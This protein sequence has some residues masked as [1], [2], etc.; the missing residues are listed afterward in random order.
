MSAS[1]NSSGY[2]GNFNPGVV[3]TIANGAPLSSVIP[4]NGFSLV[5]ILFPSAFTGATVSFEASVDGVTF[6]PVRSTLMGTLLSYT[7]TQGTYAAIDPKDFAGIAFLK[8]LSASNEGG[9]RTLTC[10]VKGI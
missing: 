2:Q 10:S 9:A 6:F 7:V 8:I 5:G 4:L 1:K 3:A